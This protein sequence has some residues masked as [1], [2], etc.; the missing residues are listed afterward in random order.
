MENLSII[1]ANYIE[2][3]KIELINVSGTDTLFVD[4]DS[5]VLE[6]KI[7][8]SYYILPTNINK[9]KIVPKIPSKVLL[10]SYLAGTG[11]GKQDQRHRN[12]V[13]KQTLALYLKQ[14]LL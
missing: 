1:Q 2:D 13:E 5:T 8:L 12:E 11:P 4:I 6:N 10:G 3:Y 9:I 7:L 14:I